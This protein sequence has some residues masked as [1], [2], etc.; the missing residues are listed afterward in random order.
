MYTIYAKNLIIFENI[1]NTPYTVYIW[2]VFRIKTGRVGI[3][4]SIDIII[5]ITIYY[6]YI[7]DIGIIK[8]LLIFST[9]GIICNYFL[10]DC[11]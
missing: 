11:F 6:I 5:S 9:V 1:V 4:K 10:G 7:I 2:E 3:F 8:C